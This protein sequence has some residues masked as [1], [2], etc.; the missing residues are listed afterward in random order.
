MRT[1]SGRAHCTALKWPASSTSRELTHQIAHLTWVFT[2]WH[3]L[4]ASDL[5]RLDDLASDCE[6][7]TKEL[8][9]ARNRLAKSEKDK[10]QVWRQ[11]RGITLFASVF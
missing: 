11:Q 4:Q 6:A 1:L 5:D 8:M 7:L 2:V 9:A 3:K 10:H